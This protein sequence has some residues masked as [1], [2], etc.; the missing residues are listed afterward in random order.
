MKVLKVCVILSNYL[1]VVKLHT[2]L[3]CPL[4]DENLVISFDCPRGYGIEYARKNFGVESEVFDLKG[5]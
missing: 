1:D 3:P 2:D 5:K 4:L